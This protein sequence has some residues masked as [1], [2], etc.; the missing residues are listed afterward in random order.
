M[1]VAEAPP[2]HELLLGDAAVRV[3]DDVMGHAESDEEAA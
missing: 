3:E 1:V 2:M